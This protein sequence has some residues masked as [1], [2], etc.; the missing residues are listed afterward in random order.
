[1]LFV[2]SPQEPSSRPSKTLVGAGVLV[3]A[4]G[5]ALNLLLG[6]RPATAAPS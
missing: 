3:T 4:V 1:M 5:W 2:E 6:T